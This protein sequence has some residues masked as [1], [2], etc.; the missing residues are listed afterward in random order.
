VTIGT[1]AEAIMRSLG[2]GMIRGMV[3]FAEHAMFNIAVLAAPWVLIL[4]GHISVSIFVDS[5][6]PKVAHLVH[7]LVEVI[8][9]VLC[10]V[11]AYFSVEIFIESFILDELIFN[12][13]V[14]PE[15][16]LLWQI[17]LAFT[18]MTI[19][20]ILRLVRLIKPS[21]SAANKVGGHHA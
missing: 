10:A 8:A 11:I 15:W 19:E 12:E 7:M 20:F 5:L 16:W 17:P 6:Q 18:L 1:G 2:I 21:A 4:N 9:I 14:I 3:D 13:L